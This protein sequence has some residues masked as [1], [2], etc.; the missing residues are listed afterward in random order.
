MPH[1]GAP[2]W[3]VLSPPHCP[4]KKQ[5]IDVKDFFKYTEEAGDIP[6]LA[7]AGNEWES[8]RFCEKQRSELAACQHI[9]APQCRRY[10]NTKTTA[11]IQIVAAA[12]VTHKL[13]QPLRPTGRDFFRKLDLDGDSKVTAED[14]KKVMRQRKLPESYATEFISAARGN[15]WWSNS[16]RFGCSHKVL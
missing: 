11:Q 4:D 13:R 2:L 1:F 9:E 7:W 15:R 5:L 6:N 8:L 10:S 3:V 14:V 12:D 16:I